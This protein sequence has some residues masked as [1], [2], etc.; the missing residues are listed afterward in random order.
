MMNG[1]LHLFSVFLAPASS[2]LGFTF[3]FH[4][5]KKLSVCSGYLLCVWDKPRVS[6]QLVLHRFTLLAVLSPC[7]SVFILYILKV[8][9]HVIAKLIRFSSVL[10]GFF[11]YFSRVGIYPHT[12]LWEMDPTLHVVTQLLDATH[13]VHPS[14][15]LE[16]VSSQ[17]PNLSSTIVSV[18]GF[19]IL[20]H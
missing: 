7:K 2:S 10:L 13:Q 4:C 1:N 15:V 12:Q 8:I 9:L 19:S 18:S 20:S 14:S 17:H 16:M 11:F 5:F 6:S 3:L